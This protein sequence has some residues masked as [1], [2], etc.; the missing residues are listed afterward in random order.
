M[1]H[2][3][4]VSV[5]T[6]GTGMAI[7]IHPIGLGI[8]RC[9]LVRDQGCI[10]IDCGAPN[11][12]RVFADA[13][14]RAGVS[15][16]EIKLIVITH[17]HWDHIGSAKEVKELTR[18][19]VAMHRLDKHGL[20]EARKLVPSKAKPWGYVIGA[21]L[22]AYLPFVRLRGVKVDVVLEN[23]DLSL[24]QYGVA[25]KVIH[26]PGHSPGSVSVLLETGEAFVG[27]LAMNGLPLRLG[28][29]LPIFADDWALVKHSLQRLLHEGAK[30]IY[31]AHGKPFPVEAIRRA[32]SS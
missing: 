8:T 31:P 20:E 25:G 22:A 15:P 32:L 1:C 10:L 16:D 29:G 12:V 3:C 11:K 19:K 17:G 6:E 21:L 24:Q 4:N 7:S 23:E 18:G 2:S 9:Y 27:D 28:P 13:L 26:T 14:R 5:Y 30:T